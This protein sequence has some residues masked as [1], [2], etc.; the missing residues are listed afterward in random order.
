VPAALLPALR[1]LHARPHTL[2]FQLTVIFKRLPAKTHCSLCHALHVAKCPRSHLTLH[3]PVVNPMSM[4]LSPVRD[5]LSFDLPISTTGRSQPWKC[6]A[7][8][9]WDVA[10]TASRDLATACADYVA[11]L[12]TP[13]AARAAPP[14]AHQVRAAT[15]HIRCMYVTC[16]HGVQAWARS[17]GAYAEHGA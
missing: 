11:R 4:Q 14:E 15:A 17:L 7:A 5:A 12:W 2:D 3:G 6:I 9:V 13:D 8:C 16:S 10:F 1:P